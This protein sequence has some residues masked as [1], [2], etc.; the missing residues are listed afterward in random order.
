MPDPGDTNDRDP[1]PSL[2]EIVDTAS[3]KLVTAFVIAGAFVALAI[4]S[5]PGP[6]RYQAFATEDKIVRVDTRRGTVIACQAT[7][8]YTVVR[9]GQRLEKGPAPAAMPSPQ[10]QRALPAPSAQRAPSPPAPPSPPTG[11]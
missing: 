6:P 4:Y 11:Q 7:R 5:R 1:P 3:R 9:R 8:C 10:P 2:G